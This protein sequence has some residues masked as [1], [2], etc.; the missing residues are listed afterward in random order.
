MS[1]HNVKSGAASQNAATGNGAPS[2]LRPPASSTPEP[3]PRKKV[4]LAKKTTKDHFTEAAAVAKYKFKKSA[5]QG[6]ANPWIVGERYRLRIPEDNFEVCYEISALA[7]VSLI[8][9]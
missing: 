1:N 7:M 3:V 2:A 5:S 8:V 6:N 4:H 9:M